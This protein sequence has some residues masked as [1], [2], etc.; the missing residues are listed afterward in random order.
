MS[1]TSANQQTSDEVTPEDVHG[2]LEVALAALD[3][4]ESLRLRN[5]ESL[6]KAYA[7]GALKLLLAGRELRAGDVID[8]PRLKVTFTDSDDG[9]L[10]AAPLTDVM[11]DKIADDLLESIELR[12]VAEEAR[13]QLLL[14]RYGLTG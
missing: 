8:T 14:E 2:A 13:T 5:R 1:D 12:L 3:N 10:L 7:N 4:F 11:V 6:K 9:P